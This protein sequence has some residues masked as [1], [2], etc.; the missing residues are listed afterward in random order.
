M[1]E[2]KERYV[3]ETKNG[4]LLASKAAVNDRDVVCPNWKQLDCVPP[5]VSK[6]SDEYVNTRVVPDLTLF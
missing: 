3:D 2:C 6:I 4:E 1:D 5:L